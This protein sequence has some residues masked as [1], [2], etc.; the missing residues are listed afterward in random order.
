MDAIQH[1]FFGLGAKYGVNP[2]VFGAIYVGAIPLFTISIAWL[3]RNARA[4]KSVVLPLLS[5]A[6]CFVSAY[7]YLI[8]VGRNVPLW[9]YGF[10][11]VMVA[12]GIVSTV[13][14][15]RRGVSAGG[16][17]GGVGG[18]VEGIEKE[19]DVVVIGGGAAGLTAAGIAA[20][21]G[22]KTLLVETAK[23][24]GDCTWTGCIPS[25][26]LLK[27][28]KV[29]HERRHAS[30]YGL[31]DGD[32]PIDSRALMNH[33]RSIRQSVYEHADAPPI[34]EAM[35]I[36]VR[37]GRA[38][39]VGPHT[40]AITTDAGKEER[41]R[42]RFIILATGG[43]P[44]IPDIAGIA[45]VPYLTS[46]SIF[47]LDEIPRRLVVV[48]GGPIGCEIAQAMRRLGA[49]VTVVHRGAHLLPK[50]D[51]ELSDLLRR[52]LE[53]EGVRIFL[54]AETKRVARDGAAILVTLAASAR[55]HVVEADAILLAT[56]R[57]PNVE[58]LD[59]AKAGVAFDKRGITVDD[60]CRTNVHH[61]YACGD[62]SGRYQLTHMSEHMAKVAATNV[63]L[64]LPSK[65]DKRHVP[66]CA[67]TD[68]E[69]AHVGATE[70]EVTKAKTAFDVYRFPFA[71][72]DR[73]ITEGE[74]LGM[75]KVFAKRASG[76]ILGA[77]ILGASAGDLI[78]ELSVAMRN[79]VTLRQ[80]ADTIHPYPTLGLGVRRAADQWYVRKRSRRFVAVLQKLFGYRGALRDF[81]PNE[82]V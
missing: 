12:F 40:L 5:A 17:G 77:T 72:I 15:V 76:K 34:F 35:G 1:W 24:G 37:H 58:G 66:W 30:R 53:A 44:Q 59:L 82:I 28:A 6:A 19:L 8:V 4:K 79:G 49:E 42:A 32:P 41:V 13:R 60:R 10:L 29:A 73:A 64:K 43:R 36:E 74:T 80:L 68:P 55:E 46:E 62:V 69:L 33:V 3:I 25:K 22:A 70:A 56:G 23:L 11:A 45:D 27:A 81:D 48:G 9:V 71:K 20:S 39:L 21:F 31:A 18:G 47:E 16:S 75:I 50:D 38:M 51:P 57:R 26:T 54:D 14:K 61:I 65:I 52:A 2:L 7:V 67:F 63:M 78:G